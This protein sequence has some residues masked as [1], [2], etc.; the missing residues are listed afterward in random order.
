MLKI[1][2]ATMLAALSTGTLL[3]AAAIQ[4]TETSAQQTYHR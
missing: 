1:L 2:S 3:T 4:A